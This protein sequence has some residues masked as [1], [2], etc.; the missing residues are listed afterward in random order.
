MS[1]IIVK[2]NI[3]TATAFKFII[4]LGLVSLFSD[5]VYEG[6]RSVIG[7]MFAILGASGAIVGFVAGLG[8]LIGNVFRIFSGYFIDRTEKYW[9][10]TFLGYGC[11]FAIPLVAFAHTWKMIAVLIIIERVGKAIRT[12]ARDAMLSYATQKIGRGVG[13]GL[14]QLF[15]QVGGMCGPLLMVI[16]LLTH[17]HYSLGFVFL[18]IPACIALIILSLG[19]KQYPNPKSLEV[20]V[21]QILEPDKIPFIFWIFLIPACLMGAGFADFP[22]IA[23]HFQKITSLTPVWIPIFY[24]IAMGVSALTALSFGWI[25][26]RIGTNILMIAVLLS[27]FFAPCIFLNGMKTAILGI[28]LWGI[29][30]GAQ[31]SLLKAIVGD[32]ISKNKRGAAFGIFNTCYG[33]AWFLGS[34]LIGI[35]YDTS[36]HGLIIFSVAAELLA[37]PFIYFVQ[38]KLK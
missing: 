4:L 22:L 18:F 15:D 9:L 6:S 26:D 38:K 21:T 36:I 29:G 16:I 17:H 35:L 19:K 3:D 23:F 27:A 20:T 10:I 11:L 32:M 31:R 28:I 37:I 12:P 34:W 2:K 30:I 7:P 25:Y 8:E 1:D 14:H 5:M 24:M 13:F 33:I